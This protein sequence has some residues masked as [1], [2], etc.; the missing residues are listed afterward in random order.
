MMEDHTRIFNCDECNLQVSPSTGKIVAIRGQK[1]VYEVSP[2]HD[3]SAL[4][5]VGTFSADGKVVKPTIIYPYV[6]IPR[7]IQNSVPDGIT[8]AKTESGWMNSQAFFEYIVNVFDDYLAKNNVKR[9]AILFIYRHSSHLT[10]QLS[11]KCEELEILL[12]MLPP[13]TKHLLQ[14]ADVDPFKPLKAYW[15]QH[16]HQFQRQHPSATVKRR[17]VAPMLSSVLKQITSDSIINGFHACG[18]S[19]FYPDAVDYSISALMWL[20][21][22]SK[23]KQMQSSCKGRKVHVQFKIMNQH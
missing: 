17:D 4:T 23:M 11:V 2:E 16:L 5:F 6:R 8:V 9:P 7:D 22:K 15:R 10:M 13:N 12:Y 3:K 1:N 19:P 14:P 20:S 18:L 21:S